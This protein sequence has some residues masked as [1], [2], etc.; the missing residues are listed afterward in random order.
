[1]KYYQVVRYD[2]DTHQGFTMIVSYHLLLQTRVELTQ[3]EVVDLKLV[4]YD[5][6]HLQ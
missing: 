4:Q 2:T 5:E 6:Y 1:M 3:K